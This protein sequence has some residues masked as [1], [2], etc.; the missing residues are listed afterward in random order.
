MRILGKLWYPHRLPSL[1]GS[2]HREAVT[3]GQTP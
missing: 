2:W 1:L 3:E